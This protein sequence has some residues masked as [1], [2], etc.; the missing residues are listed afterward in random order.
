MKLKNFKTY[1]RFYSKDPKNF[2]KRIALASTQNELPLFENISS[3]DNALK[4]SKDVP[5]ITWNNFNFSTVDLNENFSSTVYNQ[6]NL[7]S[8]KQIHSDFNEE[9]FIQKKVDDRSLVKKMKFPIIGIGKDFEEEFKTYNK[10][11]KSEKFFNLF[12]E[13]ITPSSRFEILATDDSPIH[14]QKK[15]NTASFDIEMDRWKH[16]D[17]VSKICKKINDKYSPEFYLI[18]LIEAG[19]QLYLESISRDAPLTPS[20]GVKLYESAYSKYYQSDL[21]SW[22]KK[23]M[24]EDH[25]K[26]YYSKKYYDFLFFKPSGTVDYSKY[27]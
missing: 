19:D 20:Q 3:F 27:N 25:V 15:I 16:L 5:L 21:P 13:K 22:F 10:F 4:I 17:Q 14:I 12:R 11:K 26:P 7:P 23:K 9:S 6:K 8:I 24:F 1:S 18:T 2:E